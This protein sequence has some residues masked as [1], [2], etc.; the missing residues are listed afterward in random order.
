MKTFYRLEDSGTNYGVYSCCQSDVNYVLKAH[1]LLNSLYNCPA[2][3]DD[4]LLL[5]SITRAN[6]SSRSV[7]KSNKYRFGFTS[8]KMLLNWFSKE[9]LAELMQCGIRIMCVRVPDC[10]IIVGRA[11]AVI[12]KK[13]YLART[14]KVLTFENGKF[15]S[16]AS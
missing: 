9:V 2:L 11:Q 1:G 15:K 5:E 13:E 16:V 12:S 6:L 4:E 7:R 8:R 14:K 10:E 3:E